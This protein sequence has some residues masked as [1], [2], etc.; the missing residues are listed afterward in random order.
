MV[1][2]C[3]IE[4][5]ES[6]DELKELLRDQKTASNKERVHLLYLLKSQQVESVTY[7]ASLLG[8]NRVTLER[9]L[10]KY[11]AGGI[12]QL[13]VT[14]SSVLSLWHRRTQNRRELFL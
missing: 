8:R 12:G 4:I 10:G 13:L 14:T 3:K 11:R 9:W 6:E 5:R 7:A 2:V 1:G